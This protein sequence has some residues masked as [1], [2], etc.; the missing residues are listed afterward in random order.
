MNAS[1][2]L[3]KVPANLASKVLPSTDRLD[4]A[5][6]SFPGVAEVLISYLEP[7]L[8]KGSLF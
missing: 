1:T 7:F 6:V 5:E 8:G 4:R 2:H 3:E